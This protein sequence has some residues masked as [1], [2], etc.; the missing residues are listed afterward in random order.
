MSI[1]EDSL[2]KTLSVTEV[3]KI[4]NVD[5]RNVRKHYK[6]LGGIKIGIRKIIFFEKEVVN[7]IQAQRR[8]SRPSQM[9]RRK[10]NPENNK[11]L[12][13]K[14]GSHQVGSERR[15]KTFQIYDEHGIFRKL[16]NKIS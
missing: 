14:E 9:V 1:I 10:E 11:V 16:G 15:G 2:G 3:A 8:I 4:F 5:S 6:N 7:A 12:Q 13:N